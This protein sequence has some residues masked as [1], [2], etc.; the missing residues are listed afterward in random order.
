MTEEE[1]ADWIGREMQK[2]VYELLT[3][4]RKTRYDEKTGRTV[5][6]ELLEESGTPSTPPE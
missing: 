6:I 4:P 3:D 5:Y 2:A 1:L